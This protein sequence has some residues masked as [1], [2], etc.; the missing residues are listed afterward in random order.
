M[1]ATPSLPTPQVDGTR[2]GGSLARTAV[3]YVVM[4]G[5]TVSAF[6]I[7]C[8]LGQ[9]LYA[10]STLRMDVLPTAPAKGSDVLPHIL[11]ALV[12]IFAVARLDCYFA[13][14]HRRPFR[15]GRRLGTVALSAMLVLM[16]V[17]TT[18]ATAPLV[19][20]LIPAGDED[21]E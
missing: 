5:V 18:L 12:T 1:P 19:Q 7:I 11:L 10:P 6:C 20:W 15:P 3:A 21:P 8:I 4:L 9:S 13:R 14:Q 2:P 16:S 17:T